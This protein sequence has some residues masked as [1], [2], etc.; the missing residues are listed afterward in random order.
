M[1]KELKEIHTDTGYTYKRDGDL[2]E[3]RIT[4]TGELATK[5][6][7]SSLEKTL[8]KYLEF[9]HSIGLPDFKE[10]FEEMYDSK[11][12]FIYSDSDIEIAFTSGFDIGAKLYAD[13]YHRSL[14]KNDQLRNRLNNPKGEGE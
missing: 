12:G 13:L 2:C 5:F 10:W 14:I 1:S 4:E 3:L 9:Y 6:Q 7:L 8:F 11:E